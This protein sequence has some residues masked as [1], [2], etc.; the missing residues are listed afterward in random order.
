M[1]LRWWPWFGG[2]GVALIASL[3]TPAVHAADAASGERSKLPPVIEM[4][5][6][7]ASSAAPA[8]AHEALTDLLQQ[9]ETLQTEVR[10]L[11]GQVEIQANEIERL[12]SS[13]RQLLA[14]IDKRVRDLEQRG[15][16]ASPASAATEV[17]PAAAAPPPAVNSTTVTPQEQQDYDTAI[18]FL[19]K[20]SYDR[21]A[22]GFRDFLTKYPQSTL[23]DNAR[24]WLGETYYVMRNFRQAV[25][26][27]TK[28]IR[29]NPKTPKAA[30]ILLKIGYSHYELG[31]WAKARSN[32]NQ[33]ISSYSGTPAAKS[34]E[35]RLAK[36]KKE[37]R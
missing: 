1:T 4:G 32:L 12:K 10:N 18:N 21:A 5:G 24:Y 20:G 16:S 29:E 25:D 11:R 22:K 37:G 34:A 31:E 19:K 6:G 35:Q 13:Q 30:D 17:A 23:R 9:L 15:A 3:L 2:A 26:E 28:A 7:T 8:P 36:M 27:F 14:D 33:V